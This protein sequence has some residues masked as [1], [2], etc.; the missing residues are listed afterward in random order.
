MEFKE[1]N[2]PGDIIW[3]QP[4]EKINMFLQ[5]AG[6]RKFSDENLLESTFDTLLAFITDSFKEYMKDWDP[7]KTYLAF[8]IAEKAVIVHEQETVKGKVHAKLTLLARP[9]L[10][11]MVKSL[12]GHIENKISYEEIANEISQYF[13]ME[14]INELIKT[15]IL[16]IDEVCANI[17]IANYELMEQGILS[18]NDIK[19]TIRREFDLGDQTKSS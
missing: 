1:L 7:Q 5:W 13:I 8:T 6:D 10:D 2:D 17:I 11:I 18:Y 4:R 14:K 12:N 16:Q 9:D 19:E 3:A 15:L